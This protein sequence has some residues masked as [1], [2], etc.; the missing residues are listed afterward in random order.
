ML[1]SRA[2]PNVTMDF[3]FKYAQ[4]HMYSTPTPRWTGSLK[5]APKLGIKTWLTI[6]NDDYF[7]LS[8]GDPGFV[9]DFMAGIPEKRM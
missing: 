9:R 3:S 5:S 7:Y 8:W 6:R 2:L 4:A 1:R